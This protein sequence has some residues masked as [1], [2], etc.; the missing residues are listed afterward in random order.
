MADAA[1]PRLLYIADV[2]VEASQHGSAF[3]MLLEHE[4]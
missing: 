4:H 2:P 1:L 3:H